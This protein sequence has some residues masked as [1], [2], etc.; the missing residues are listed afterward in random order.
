MKKIL[1]YAA[2]IGAIALIIAGASRSVSYASEAL[3]MCFEMIIPTLFPFFI[4][5]GLLIYSGFCEVLAKAFRFCMMPLFRINPAGSSAFILGIVSG[6]PL[7]AV[8][9]GELYTNNYLSKT[10]AERLLAFCNNSG[11]LFILGSVGAAVYSDMRLGVMLY[12]SHILAALTVGIIFRF[13]KTSKYVAPPTVMG[14]PKR[15][16]GEIFNIALQ[17][18]ISSILTVCGAVLFFSVI[19]R[20][21]LDLLPLSSGLDA[22]ASGVCEFVTGTLK[23]SSLDVSTASK[24]ILT[25][26]VVGFAGLS[27]H[28]QV[29]AVV[30]KYGLSLKPYMIG[31]LLHGMI[32]AFY[33]YIYLRL[34]PIAAFTFAP[35]AGRAFAAVSVYEAIFA[36]IAILACGACAI[37]LYLRNC[38]CD[39]SAIESKKT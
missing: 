28:I 3:D 7:G 32:A 38:N 18:A 24:M 4:C 17:N 34:R 39:K 31:K 27:V 23:I 15:P 16:I 37:W 5:S 33:T 14:T 8:T 1:L 21:F 6:Y 2:V 25:S 10:E 35:S 22:V 26:A 20:L 29:M 11:P 19:S 13:Y 30:S 9:A 36:A 12:V